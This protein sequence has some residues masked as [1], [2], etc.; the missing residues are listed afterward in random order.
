MKNATLSVDEG[1]LAVVRR[2]AAERDSS[3]NRLV[4]E[5]LG[6]IATR[7]DRAGRARQRGARHVYERNFLSPGKKQR[8]VQENQPAHPPHIL[9]DNVPQS[10]GC[11]AGTGFP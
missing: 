7:E 5:F 8:P 3:V 1:V 11:Q 4:R 2:Y 9:K 10:A 6:G